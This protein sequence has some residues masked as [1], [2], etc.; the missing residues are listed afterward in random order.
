VL[1]LLGCA[2]GL[3]LAHWTTGFL[4]R[5][6]AIALRSFVD[7][8]V[9]LPVM[10]VTAALALLCGTF[11]GLARRCWRPGSIS[12]RGSK[13][14]ALATTSAPGRRR[15]QAGLVIVEVGLALALLTGAGLMIK[16]FRQFTRTDLGLR[17]RGC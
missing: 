10:G 7:A 9:D 6:G 5:S 11:F 3:L 17:P 13:E 2:L 12:S 8:R 1:S 15:F 14:G 4:A 16:G